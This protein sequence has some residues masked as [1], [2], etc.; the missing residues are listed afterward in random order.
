M[1][2]QGLGLMQRLGGG[3]YEGLGLMQRLG[4]G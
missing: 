1:Q 3:Q 2:R 4:G